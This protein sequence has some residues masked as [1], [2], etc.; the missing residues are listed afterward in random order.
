LSRNEPIS[1]IHL[2]GDRSVSLY[3]GEDA[4]HVRL[5]NPPYQVK[6]DKLRQVLATLQKKNSRAAYVYLDNSHHS[7][8]VTVRMR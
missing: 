7:G 2:E 5:G 1:E 3:V 6:L 8:R 4:T